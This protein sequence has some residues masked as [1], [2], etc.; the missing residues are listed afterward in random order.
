MLVICCV[1]IH[2]EIFITD[3]LVMSGKPSELLEP[4]LTSE[5]S[6]DRL[7]RTM[8]HGKPEIQRLGRSSVLD[9]VSYSIE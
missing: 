3:L 7:V 2:S 9:E 8:L 5:A 1:E 6:K 4:R